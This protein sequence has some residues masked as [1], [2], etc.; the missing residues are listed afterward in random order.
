ME[1][2]KIDMA[3]AATVMG[4]LHY[5]LETKLKKNLIIGLPLV[6]NMVSH[7]AYKPGDVITM[8]NGKTVEVG[9][10]DAEGRLILGD[11]L[12]YIE[13][14]Y[15]PDTVFD[16]ATLTGAQII[17]LG[18]RF[19]AILGRNKELNRHIQDLGETLKDRTRE[20]PF[21]QPYFKTYK[22]DIADM[23]NM[24]TSGRM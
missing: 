24:S 19:A 13:E 9:N 15:N 23:N 21:Y 16:F 2:M 4:V 3:G 22:S 8:Y 14:K 12:S 11:T 18:N 20:L 10:T 5:A 7:N 17:A 1:D 6:E